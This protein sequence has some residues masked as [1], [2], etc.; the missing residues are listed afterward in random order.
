MTLV[1]SDN[2]FWGKRIL[3]LFLVLCGSLFAEAKIKI[4]KH[5]ILRERSLCLMVD[6][7]FP[8]LV[9]GNVFWKGRGLGVSSGK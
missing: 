3:A 1:L 7:L 6:T 2:F 9:L 5:N 4:I 8:L